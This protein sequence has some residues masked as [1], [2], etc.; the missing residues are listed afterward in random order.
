MI[1]TLLAPPMCP[2]AAAAI[3]VFTPASYDPGFG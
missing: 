3:L 1:A 2:A